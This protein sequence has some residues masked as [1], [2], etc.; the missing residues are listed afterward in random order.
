M[1]VF[2][3]RVSRH[4]TV[5]QTFFGAHTCDGDGGDDE[6]YDDY[7]G[8]DEMRYH[9]ENTMK[10]HVFDYHDGGEEKQQSWDHNVYEAKLWAPKKVCP[11][12]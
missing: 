7:N 10:N 12:V 3:C 11:V 5:G 8:D 1:A 6:W 9:S 4:Q 2:F